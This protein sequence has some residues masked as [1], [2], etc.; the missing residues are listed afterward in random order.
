MVRDMAQSENASGASLA[1]A[2]GRGE[3]EKA[4]GMFRVRDAGVEEFAAQ[5]AQGVVGA[6]VGEVRKDFGE[7][8]IFVERAGA[9]V[10]GFGGVE[11]AFRVEKVG[12]GESAEEEACAKGRTKIICAS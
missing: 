6:F 12:V 4:G 9:A 8:L 2:G 5:A 1:A 10:G 3:G 7:S 11:V